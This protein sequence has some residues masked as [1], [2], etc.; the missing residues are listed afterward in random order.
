V[1]GLSI[2]LLYGEQVGGID[3][4][5]VCKNAPSV[6]HFLFADNF[7]IL[8]MADT[9]NVT[10]LQQI[11]DFYCANSGQFVKPCIKI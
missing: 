2:L 8:M 1:E 5:R 7:L 9:I 11:L 3:G 6:F 4:I 10:S